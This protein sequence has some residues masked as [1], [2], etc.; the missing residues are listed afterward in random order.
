MKRGDF[1]GLCR[2]GSQDNVRHPGFRHLNQEG[3][4]KYTEIICQHH[5]GLPEGAGVGTV[6]HLLGEYVDFEG[7]DVEV[8]KVSEQIIRDL[9]YAQ[10]NCKWKIGKQKL[11]HLLYML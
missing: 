6:P 11:K 2:R 8:A 9:D 10:V 5:K 1:F 7:A 3:W 4:H